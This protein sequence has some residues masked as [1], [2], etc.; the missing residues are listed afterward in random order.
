VP[1]S[2]SEF[3]VPLSQTLF[4]ET[5][6]SHLEPTQKNRM[7]FFTHTFNLPLNYF[8]K[9]SLGDCLA[10]WNEFKVNTVLDIKESDEHFRHLCF[11]RV[12]CLRSW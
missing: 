9:V 8:N 6:R 12:N 10:L 7:T 2:L 4:M 3:F 5:A 1:S 11:E